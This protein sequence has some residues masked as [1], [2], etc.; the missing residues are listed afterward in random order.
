MKK[1]ISYI[2]LVIFCFSFTLTVHADIADRAILGD[3]I[4]PTFD[5]ELSDGLVLFDKL[6][7]PK[8]T[9]EDINTE[10]LNG[11]DKVYNVFD[12]FGMKTRFIPYLGESSFNVGLLDHIYTAI[13]DDK[14]KDLGIFDIFYKSNSYLSTKAYPTRLPVLTKA[15]IKDGNI[16][17]ARVDIYDEARAINTLFDA[18]KGNSYLSFAEIIVSFTNFIM[19]DTLEYYLKQIINLLFDSVFWTD[20]VR[21]IAKFVLAFAVFVW[22]IILVSKVAKYGRGR[23]PDLRD[24]FAKF[25]TG[26]IAIIILTVS[27]QNPK[28]M[29]NWLFKL[30]DIIQDTINNVISDSITDED[31]IMKSDYTDNA[32]ATTMWLN[33]IYVNWCKGMFGTT[34]D[35]LYTQYANVPDEQKMPQDIDIRTGDTWHTG[36]LETPYYDSAYYTGDIEVSHGAESVKNWAEFAL[37]TQSIYHISKVNGNKNY[38][39]YETP[40]IEVNIEKAEKY[41]WPVSKTAFGNKNIYQDTFRWIDAKLNIGG[42]FTITPPD[43]SIKK[44]YITD[45]DN[46]T[47][48]EQSFTKYGR[49]A[50]VDCVWL[51][52]LWPPAFIKIISFGMLVINVIFL[53]WYSFADLF[54]DRTRFTESFKRV[55]HYLMQYL[56]ASIQVF[57]ILLIYTKLKPKDNIIATIVYFLMCSLIMLSTYKDIAKRT[58][59]LYRKIK[60]S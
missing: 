35:K 40:D 32:Q 37:S 3:W 57:L 34:Y 31:P 23:T 24:F 11:T 6:F 41:N 7:V 36:T 53:I 59:D 44:T 54:S 14:T 43:D 48:Y 39:G 12:R 29:S 46:A 50:A 47:G 4:S 33:T 15:A 21:D 51:L 52:P 55:G 5:I 10:I 42:K 8:K 18:K 20:V 38:E 60:R 22:M 28:I 9:I 16:Q 27:L 49:Q 17:D 30:T 13:A 45:Y 25:I 19:G 2:L 58:K 56:F 26:C 1:I